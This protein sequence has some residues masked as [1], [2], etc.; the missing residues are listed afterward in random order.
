[1]TILFVSAIWEEHKDTEEV[2]H[3]QQLNQPKSNIDELSDLDLD[4]DEG[5]DEDGM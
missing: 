1:M 5:D 4:T 2:S 3:L